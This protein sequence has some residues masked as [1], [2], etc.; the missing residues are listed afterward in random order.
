MH[1]G[2]DGNVPVTQTLALAAKLAALGKEF[3]VVVFPGGN[4][5]LSRHQVERDRQ[6]IEFFRSHRAD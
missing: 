3:G 6:A 4:H 1:G 2:A 5:T